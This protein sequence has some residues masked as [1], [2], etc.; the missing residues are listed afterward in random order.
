MTLRRLKIEDWVSSQYGSNGSSPLRETRAQKYR[1][2]I[3]SPMWA[4]RRAD[5]WRSHPKACQACGA[6]KDVHLHHHT[7]ERMGFELDGDLVPLCELCHERVHEHH[8][9]VGGDLT[10][11]TFRVIEEVKAKSAPRHR[12]GVIGEAEADALLLIDAEF[13]LDECRSRDARSLVKR[14]LG[15]CPECRWAVIR[16]LTRVAAAGLRAHFGDDD[17][18]LKA[19]LSDEWARLERFARED[20]TS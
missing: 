1:R 4:A 6:T 11:A 15:R 10:E 20:A 12:C 9:A 14:K 3:D 17:E 5:Y 2:Y 8:K 13:A 18:A 16:S 19:A 7:Y